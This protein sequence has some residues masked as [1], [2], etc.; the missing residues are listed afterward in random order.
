MFYEALRHT[1]RMTKEVC[2]SLKDLVNS[3]SM[4]KSI[5]RSRRLGYQILSEE[6]NGASPCSL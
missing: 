2:V 3:M 6:L 5:H 4:G 1:L